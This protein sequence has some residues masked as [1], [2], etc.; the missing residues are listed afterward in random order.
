VAHYYPLPGSDV[1]RVHDFARFLTSSG[2]D[3]SIV[4]RMNIYDIFRIKAAESTG[5]VKVYRAISLDLRLSEVVPDAFQILS[6]FLLSFVVAI[7]HKVDFIIISVPPGVPGIGA[8]LAGKVLRKKIVFDVRDKWEEHSIYFSN[9]GLARQTHTFLK[10][11]FDILYK[12]A[13]LVVTVTPSLLKYLKTRGASQ[14][15]LVPNGADVKLF[16]PRKQHEKYAVRSELGLKNEDII[17]VYAGAIGDYYKTDVV[18][19]A[20]YDL[21]K[22]DNLLNVKFVVMGRGEPS[23]IREMLA[24]V[25][26]LGLQ[27]NVIFLGK[28]ERED[29][30]RILS[31]CDVGIVPYDD[32]PLW[33]SAYSTKFFEYCASGL[34]VIATVSEDADLAVLIRKFEMGYIVE[35]L[36][37]S[38]FKRAVKNFYDLSEKEKKSMSEKARRLAVNSY[39]RVDLAKKLMENLRKV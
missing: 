6:T 30:A 24:L 19:K 13:N 2:N 25:K 5:S 36:N 14:V 1:F 37:V 32:N 16:C 22:N 28:K 20:L 8:F 26:R 4:S 38:Q 29:V 10:R 12:E 18:I 35:P 21:T 7:I 34:P 31:C 17:L 27:N 15:S 3:V 11:L 9:Y 23:K 39:D 33:L